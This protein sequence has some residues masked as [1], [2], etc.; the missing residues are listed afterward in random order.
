MRTTSLCLSPFIL[1]LAIACSSTTSTV[2]QPIDA[3][4]TPEQAEPDPTDESDA[5]TTFK[6]AVTNF[7]YAPAKLTIKVGDTVQWTWKEGTHTV[8]SGSDCVADEKLESGKHTAPFTF[9]H[10]FTEAGTVNYFCDYM[11][12][13]TKG[14]RGVI[15][16][17]PQ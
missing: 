10:K 13:C 5:G 4:A 8:S 15:V 3:G 6:V 14:Q 7:A 12:H 16:V 2:T 17:A 9:R 11:E 1:V